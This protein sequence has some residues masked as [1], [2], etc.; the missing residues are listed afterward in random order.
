MDLIQWPFVR[1]TYPGIDNPIF[2]DDIKAADQG[3]LAAVAAMS[4]LGPVDFAIISGLEYITTGP[5]TFNPGIFY[6][7]G[8]FYF[9]EDGFNEGL[10]LMPSIQT[11]LS[12]G[13]D[14]GNT[15]V[16][17]NTQ[18]GITS[19]LN[20]GVGPYTPLFMGNMNQYRMGGKTV[21]ANINNLLTIAAALGN[22]AFK[23]V[24]TTPGTLA[25]GDDPRLVYTAAQLDLRFAQIINVI[26]KGAGTAYTPLSATDPANKG[27]VDGTSARRIASGTLHVG[28]VPGAG[29]LITVSIGSTLPDANY[30]VFG[31]LISNNPGSPGIDEIFVPLIRSKTT[32]FFQVWF[33]ET[34]ANVQNL[35]WDWIIFEK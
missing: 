35:D 31:Q 4:G 23:S 11:A 25:A 10:Y 26:I 5:N 14:D 6:L 27:Y 16:I 1:V 9:I 34:A 19:V 30:M 21:L 2:D 29:T 15:R 33:E 12:K 22:G 20:T 28:D 18:F 8:T 3:I 32:T 13:F 24:G 7:N 17:Y